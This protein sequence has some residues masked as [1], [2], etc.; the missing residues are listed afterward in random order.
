MLKLLHELA[1]DVLNQL[2]LHLGGQCLVQ[3]VLLHNQ[4]EI[5]VE[6]ISHRV[7][8]LFAELWVHEVRLV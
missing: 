6:S 1:K 7:L 2:S 5:E 4:V 8:D 3:R